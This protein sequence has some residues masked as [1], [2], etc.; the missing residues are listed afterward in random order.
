M[1][2]VETKLSRCLRYLGPSVNT[3]YFNFRAGMRCPLC[4]DGE[5]FKRVDGYGL[6]WRE[7]HL[8][9]WTT[10]HYIGYTPGC[11]DNGYSCQNE[12][13]VL[14]MS[15]DLSKDSTWNVPK[16]IVSYLKSIPQIHSVV[17]FEITDVELRTA[18]KEIYVSV[19]CVCVCLFYF[20]QINYLESSVKYRAIFVLRSFQRYDNNKDAFIGHLHIFNTYTGRQCFVMP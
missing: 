18:A 15:M 4:E 8:R 3:L 12:K 6:H 16:K 2:A 14:K 10:F 17:R 7:K 20:I 1:D 13:G 5:E 19:Q 11:W 9:S